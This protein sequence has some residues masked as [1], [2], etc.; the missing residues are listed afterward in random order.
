MEEKEINTLLNLKNYLLSNIKSKENQITMIN[1]EIIELN[2]QIESI[3]SIISSS[4]FSTAANLL[5]AETAAKQADS[6]FDNMK[7][8]HKIYSKSQELLVSLQFKTNSIFIRLIHPDKI[9]LTQEIYINY[10]VKPIL[11]SL[12]KIE[13][14]LTPTITKNNYDNQEYIDTIT[15]NNIHNFESFEYICE[16]MKKLILKDK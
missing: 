7:Y 4:S 11:V 10:F 1:S 14:N 2:N 8:S 16:S 13:A 9:Q 12:K 15:L 5:D 3:N 6:Q